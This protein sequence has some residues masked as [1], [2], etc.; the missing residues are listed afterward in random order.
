MKHQLTV[1]EIEE[2]FLVSSDVVGKKYSLANGL[3]GYLLINRKEKSPRVLLYARKKN[4]HFDTWHR[5][6]L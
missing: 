1:F 3:R 5:L 2:L 6:S 4:L